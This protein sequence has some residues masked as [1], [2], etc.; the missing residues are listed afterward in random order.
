M[1][2]ASSAEMDLD[3]WEFIS[4]DTDDHRFHDIQFSREMGFDQKSV[5]D[6]DYFICPSPTPSKTIFDA[7]PKSTGLIRRRVQHQLVP[8]PI[9]LEPVSG[10]NPDHEFVK[11][12]TEFSVSEMVEKIIAPTP[13][14]AVTGDQD[15]I[16]QVFFKKMKENEFVDMKM[17]SP[18]SVNT[19]IKPQAELGS[20][21]FEE[22]DQG[23]NGE[24]KEQN[25]PSSRVAAEQGMMEDYSDSKIKVESNWE[26][27]DTD[28]FCIW[29]WGTSGIG[30]LCSV[31]VAAATICIFIFGSHQRHKHHLNQ[32]QKLNFQIYADDKRI[33]EMVNHSTRLN[34][35]LSTVRGVPLTRATISFGGIG[36][37][38]TF[39][40]LNRLYQ[41][42]GEAPGTC[43]FSGMATIAMTDPSSFS[44]D[45]ESHGGY[46]C[47][48]CGFV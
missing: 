21:Q 16:S 33:K 9:Q 15:V 10:K 1:E 8:I 7:P 25:R 47:R 46:E 6:M 31:G 43:D 32:H 17:D 11:D 2:K 45:G 44:E 38:S 19:G 14:A 12:I 28:G 3:E 35:A 48:A 18:K 36:A 5:L 27:G 39:P 30:T 42:K 37:L 29:K 24:A 26:E 41:C 13:E 23:F 4:D 40:A 34:H 20:I 22:K